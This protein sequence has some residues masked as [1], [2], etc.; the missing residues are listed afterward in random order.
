MTILPTVLKKYVA[1]VRAYGFDFSKE[2]EFL[3]ND[4]SISTAAIAIVS[5]GS[6]L[7]IGTPTIDNNT[8]LVTALMSAGTSGTNYQLSCTITT[9][10]GKTIRHYGIL[11]VV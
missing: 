5:G 11:Q 9:G 8:Y 2:P 4:D 3:R 1:E 10:A 7:I 6:A